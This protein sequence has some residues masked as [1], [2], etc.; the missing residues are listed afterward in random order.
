MKKMVSHRRSGSLVTPLKKFLP[1]FLVAEEA[2][3]YGKGKVP[4]IALRDDKENIYVYQGDSLIFLEMLHHKYPQGIF[5]L[6][7]ADPPYFLSSD[8]I[9]CQA[10]KMVSVNKGDWDKIDS[11]NQMHAFNMSW[12]SACQNALKPDGTIFISGTSHVI[13]SIGFALQ[14]LEF[15]TLNDI[16]W[17]K[18]NPPPNLSCRYFTHASEMIIW[19]AKNKKSKHQFNYEIMRKAN[20]NRQMKSVFYDIRWDDRDAHIIF[21]IMP[22]SKEEKAFGKHPTQKPLMLLERL[23][24]AASSKDDMVFDPFMGSGT[25]AVAAKMLKR[26][27]VG[28]ELDQE[29][30]DIAIK[31]INA[32]DELKDAALFS[33]MPAE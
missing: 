18:P 9:T 29:Y 11:L 23:I 32:V 10:G 4:R 19:A 1:D 2:A 16:T 12:L 17:V 13:H 6:I 27:F 8:G 22:P 33:M 24:L 5:D 30:I 7:F 28:C 3:Y 20:G 21:E 25:T 26:R 31:R 14:Q 15:K